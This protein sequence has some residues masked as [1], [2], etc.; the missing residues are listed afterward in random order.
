MPFSNDGKISKHETEF[1]HLN[2]WAKVCLWSSSF[3][4]TFL[5]LPQIWHARPCPIG[6]SWIY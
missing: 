6:R 1:G 4:H 2:E 3:F 5:L